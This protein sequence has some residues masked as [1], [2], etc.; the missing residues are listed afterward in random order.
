MLRLLSGH[1]IDVLRTLPAESVHTICT[2]PPYWGLRDYKTEPV[3]WGGDPG[4]EHEWGPEV[5][6]SG[7][8]QI[9]GKTSQRAGSSNIM[10]QQARGRSRGSTCSRCG[11]WRGSLGGESL[12][13]CLSW[14][15]GEDP[16]PVCY[17]C[18]LRAVWRELWRVLRKDGT[19]W[20]VI[21]DSQAS[22]GRTSYDSDAKS[23]ARGGVFRP[24][25][26]RANGL[27]DERGQRNRDGAPTAPGLKPKDMAGIPWRVALALQHDGWYLR[28]DIV[29]AK[30]NPMPESVTDRCTRS[31][32]LV[33]HFSRGERYY[34]DR[35]GIAEESLRAGKRPGGNRK[36]DASRRDSGRDMSIPVA[37]TRNLRDVWT[38]ATVPYKGAHFAV[39]PPRLVEPCIKAGTSEAG[40]CPRCGAPWTRI[41]ERETRNLSNAARAGTEIEGKGHPTSQ[42]REDH[43][44]RNGPTPLVRSLGWRQACQ[45]P[46][47]D[48]I[49]CTVLDPFCGSGTAGAVA[50]ALGRS[51]VG[52][53]LN[54]DYLALARRRIA[55]SVQRSHKEK[56]CPSATKP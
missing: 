19:C 7:P 47:Q 54:P 14:A 21:G 43:D 51:F 11:A 13:D 9:Q 24:G 44:I 35:D 16:C 3:I 56:P 4:C 5:I 36:V 2:S 6:L 42:V 17:V 48:P 37:L 28:R 38:I 55:E 27:V 32:E 40:C 49:P 23:L 20:L 46:A 22:G 29:W 31:H 39:F 10:E 12:H 1:V 33:L 53:E 50:L 41:T 30:P 52:I 34:Y 25:C 18:H 8:A 26:G 45:C 15:R